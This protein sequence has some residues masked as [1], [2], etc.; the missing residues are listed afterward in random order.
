MAPSS[1]LSKV[2]QVG[3][4]FVHLL[5][6]GGFAAM[7]VLS[8][9]CRVVTVLLY[10]LVRS[11]VRLLRL[12]VVR[13][14][15]AAQVDQAQDVRSHR[16]PRR[17]VLRV[18]ARVGSSRARWW[19]EARI[20]QD[21][22]LDVGITRRCR[23]SSRC[24]KRTCSVVNIVHVL[25]RKDNANGRVVDEDPLRLDT[26]GRIRMCVLMR[27]LGNV[28]QLNRLILFERL[29]AGLMQV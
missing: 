25:L 28:L 11:Q 6:H 17:D 3:Q 29:R 1:T 5:V 24:V 27:V 4:E 14:A 20:T 21:T 15:R 8:V 18:V 12:L 26:L 7:L 2:L 19:S 10:C 22:C 9:V 16:T 13:H 23:V